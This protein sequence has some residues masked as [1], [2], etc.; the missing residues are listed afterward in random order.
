MQK[1]F[2]FSPGPAL[3]PY[4][5]LKKAQNELINWNNLNVSVMEISH[6]THDFMNL[7]KNIKKDLRELI[8][9]PSEYEI[10]FCQGGARTQFSAIPMNLL[11]YDETADY[12]NIG[13]WSNEAIKEATKY[14]KPHIINPLKKKNGLYYIEKMKYWSLNNN[15][16]YIHYCP[17]ETIE[18][19]AINEEPK[20]ENKTVIADLS[21][22]ILAQEINIKNYGMIYA[23]AQKNIGPAGLTIIIIKKKLILNNK[24]RKELPSVLDYKIMSQHNS[25]FNTP[26]TFSL[27]LSGLVLKWLKKKGGIK[28]ISKINKK[29]AKLLYSTIDR[30]K[31]YINKIKYRN[32]SI[33]NVVF[34]LQDPEKENLFLKKSQ[35]NGLFYLKGHKKIG[36]IRASIYNAMPIEGI[37]KLINFMNDFETKYI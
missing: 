33:T 9:I 4:E 5:V 8:D 11:Y 22:I 16:K 13:H 25:M 34:H 12:A 7:I 37:K 14:C 28:F 2:N 26:A 10:L 32:R 1:I 23:S 31:F 19:I 15:S 20:F 27:Y 29:K 30:S 6:R 21:S 36:G 18:G 24:K 35:E 17:N 3:L